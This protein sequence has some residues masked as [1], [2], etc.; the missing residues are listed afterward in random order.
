MKKFLIILSVVW[1]GLGVYQHSHIEDEV[2]GSVQELLNKNELGD[3]KVI[4][5]RI[6]HSFTFLNE[7][8]KSEVVVRYK[9]DSHSI[10]INLTPYGGTPVLSVFT[11]FDR[12]QI[13]LL[14]M[15]MLGLKMI[16]D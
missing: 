15:E 1:V 5:I 11:G 3:L 10:R 14:P 12:Y 8:V 16:M 7:S 6:P 13:G 4:D 9:E 2:Q